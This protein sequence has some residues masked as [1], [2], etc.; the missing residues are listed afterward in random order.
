[1]SESKVG[2][3]RQNFV[4]TGNVVEN[5]QIAFT[6]EEPGTTG[7]VHSCLQR[8]DGKPAVRHQQDPRDLGSKERVFRHFL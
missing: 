4:G 3:N 5:Q 8:A 2:T 7:G 1:M 6:K